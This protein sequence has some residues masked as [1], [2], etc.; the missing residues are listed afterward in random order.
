MPGSISWV[1]GGA[2][3]HAILDHENVRGGAFLQVAV[4]DQQGF[5][6]AFF[7]RLLARQDVGE[8]RN[9]FEVATRPAVVGQR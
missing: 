8:Q 4:A 1:L 2:S 9:D 3:K 7:D 5:G 6:A